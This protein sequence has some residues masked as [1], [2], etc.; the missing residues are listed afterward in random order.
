MRPLC[1]APCVGNTSEKAV[2]VLAWLGEHSS[3]GEG[4][5]TKL[6]PGYTAKGDGVELLT[7]YKHVPRE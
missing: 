1:S 5:R 4:P 6:H 7:I 3:E 2:Q